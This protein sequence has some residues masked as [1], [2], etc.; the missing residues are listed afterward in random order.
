M[1]KLSK[2]KKLEIKETIITILYVLVL[3]AFLSLI[4]MF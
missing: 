1:K 4:V 2:E 3:I